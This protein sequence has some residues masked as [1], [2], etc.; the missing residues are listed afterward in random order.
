MT[1]AVSA[2]G[3]APTRAWVIG[4][5]LIGGSVAAALTERGWHV[6]VTDTDESTL[7][8]AIERGIAHTIGPDPDAVHRVLCGPGGGHPRS[9]TSR[10]F[11]LRRRCHRRRIDQENGCRCGHRRPIRRWPSDGR[12]GA[13]W[14]RRRRSGPVPQRH[15][16]PHTP[17]RHR[18]VGVRHRSNGG[19]EPWSRGAHHAGGRARQD[20]RPGVPRS[21]SDRRR[22][23]DP[24]RRIVGRASSPP[25]AGGW[26]L[27]GHDKDQRR[28]TLPSGPTSSPRTP[29]RSAPASRASSHSST[30]SAAR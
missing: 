14:H 30:A 23:H 15:M 10:P 13:G 12:I 2:N 29:N 1:D 11:G 6:S 28:S 7:A 16:G 25:E 9:C 26:R 24:R 21:P 8:R 4:C 3:L 27:Q 20:G 17:S 18:G 19:Q 22:P 5:G